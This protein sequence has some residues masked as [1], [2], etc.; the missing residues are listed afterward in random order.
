MK[1]NPSITHPKMKA[2]FLVSLMSLCLG[3]APS[4]LAQF[5]GAPNY[6]WDPTINYIDPTSSGSAILSGGGDVTFS[7][8]IGAGTHYDVILGGT[9]NINNGYNKNFIGL[10]TAN[11]ITGQ[12]DHSGIL[13]DHANQIGADAN[14]EVDDSWIL[15]GEANSIIHFSD[16]SVIAGGF[17]NRIDGANNVFHNSGIGGGAWNYIY[18]SL[19]AYIPGGYANTISNAEYSLALGSR[20]LLSASTTFALGTDN[21][22]STANSI[23]IG[24]A[25]KGIRITGDGAVTVNTIISN[26]GTAWLST[27]NIPA[28]PLP[29]GSLATVTDGRFFLRNNGNWAMVP[30]P[31]YIQT[32]NAGPHFSAA[33]T[34]LFGGG[35]G[36]LTLPASTII[37]GSTY[38]IKLYCLW[39]A[40]GNDIAPRIRV[41]YGTTVIWDSASTPG[42]TPTFTQ[43]DT[44]EGAIMEFTLTF[45]SVGS[46]GA[47]ICNGAISSDTSP[48][49]GGIANSF[50]LVPVSPTTV[51]TTT[52]KAL[53][54]TAQFNNTDTLTGVNAVVERLF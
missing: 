19:T 6:N 1:F 48:Q 30:V 39:A 8:S 45:R 53:D 17:G 34:S 26:N 27:N 25:N 46:S 49:Y 24:F 47:V 16:W 4:L 37:A 28:A 23:S 41:R 35:V 54:I 11:I 12:G 42:G 20:N 7:N 18:G 31:V 9:A 10:G 13:G 15:G 52:D 5:Y 29:N 21:T 22:N 51:N 2:A 43:T 36:S 3:L 40:N 38:R 50:V 14:D 32:T 44:Q 33:E